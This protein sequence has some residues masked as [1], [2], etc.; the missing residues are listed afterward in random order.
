[1]WAMAVAT[2]SAGSDVEAAND[3]LWGGTDGEASGGGCPKET[4]AKLVQKQPSQVNDRDK[5]C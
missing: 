4:R 5:G 2:Q 1:M 3:M